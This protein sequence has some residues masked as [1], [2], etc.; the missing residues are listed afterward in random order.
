MTQGEAA[1]KRIPSWLVF[2]LLFVLPAV[3]A[4]IAGDMALY[5]HRVDYNNLF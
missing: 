2:G 3:A 5:H 4:V 1:N